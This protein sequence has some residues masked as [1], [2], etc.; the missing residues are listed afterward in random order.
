MTNNSLRN[1]RSRSGPPTQVNNLQN[2]DVQTQTISLGTG[3]DAY[4]DQR[5]QRRHHQ[6][7]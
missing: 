6:I 2:I 5:R 7:S 1:T 3:H 4:H